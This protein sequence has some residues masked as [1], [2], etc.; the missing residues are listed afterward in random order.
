MTVNSEGKDGSVGGPFENMILVFTWK[1]EVNERE[2]E[3]E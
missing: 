3:L 1:T 2:F